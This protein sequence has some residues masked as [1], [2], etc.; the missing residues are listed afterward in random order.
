MFAEK[1]YFKQRN[2]F[3]LSKKKKK[4]LFKK[5]LWQIKKLTLKLPKPPPP[6]ALHKALSFVFIF[7]KPRNWKRFELEKLD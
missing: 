1:K 2:F 7:T 4:N 5:T 3:F 6:P